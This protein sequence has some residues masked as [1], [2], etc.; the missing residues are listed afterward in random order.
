MWRWR[1]RDRARDVAIERARVKQE[2]RD[3]KN[4]F[5]VYKPTLLDWI[6]IDLIQTEI[7]L[8]KINNQKEIEMSEKPSFECRGCR[9]PCFLQVGFDDKDNRVNPEHCPFRVLGADESKWKR[10][11]QSTEGDSMKHVPVIHEKKSEVE[12]KPRVW[13]YEMVV[14]GGQLEV[15][16]VDAKTGELIARLVRIAQDG[17][18]HSVGRAENCLLDGDE[19]TTQGLQFDS[20]EAIAVKTD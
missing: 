7:E 12:E 8:E 3:G 4:G 2:M 15:N 9:K 1:K 18:L 19:Y 11:E 10:V 20:F 13:E 14:Q 17:M 5:V 6:D 16:A